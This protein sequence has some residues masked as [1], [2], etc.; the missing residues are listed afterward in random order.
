MA[1]LHKVSHLSIKNGIP[2]LIYEQLN[3]INGLPIAVSHFQI[4]K[5]GH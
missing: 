5:S 1:Y 3:L 2:K 4:F